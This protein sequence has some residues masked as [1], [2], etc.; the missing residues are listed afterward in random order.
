MKKILTKKSKKAKNVIRYFSGENLTR[1][2]TTYDVEPS[3]QMITNYSKSTC[4]C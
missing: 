2:M 1:E 4:P 3:C